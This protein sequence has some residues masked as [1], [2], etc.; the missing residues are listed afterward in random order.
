MVNILMLPILN[1]MPPRVGNPPMGQKSRRLVLQVYGDLA[2][3]LLR[4]SLSFEIDAG[5][6][7]AHEVDAP[8]SIGLG[9]SQR[10]GLSGE[11][12]G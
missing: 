2:D 12:L 11:G 3:S 7:K 8:D 5:D 10:D 9:L 4:T 6:M 1:H